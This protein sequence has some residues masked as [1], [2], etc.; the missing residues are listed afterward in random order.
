MMTSVHPVVVALPL[1]HETPDIVATAAEFARRIQA[2]IVV[3]HAIPTRR[4]ESEDGLAARRDGARLRLE[5]YLAPL[6][7]AGVV[8]QDVTVEL[9][10]P[11]EVILAT[12][13]RRAAQMV[14][15]GGGRPA[16]VRRWVVGSVAEAVVRRSS[17][18]VWIARGEPPAGR[19]VLCPVDASPEARVGIDAAIRMARLFAVPLSLMTVV[20]DES[21]G[22]A[23][24]KDQTEAHDWLEALVAKHD[25][26]GLDVS[27]AVAV[28][29][30][31]ERIV[32]AA[33][34]A[35]LAVI[36]S[37]GYDPLIRDWLGPVTMRTLRN[38][39]CSTLTIRHLAEGHDMRMQAI[40]RVAD[41]YQQAKA[42]LVDDHGP[43]A[44]VLLE[45]IVEQAPT[46]AAIQDAYAI[47]LERVGRDVEATSRHAL[48]QLIRD[49]LT[50]MP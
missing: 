15:T 19:P 39:R 43:E 6:R 36:A 8:I 30:P 28:G 41:L 29:D 37:R 35:S 12:A 13:L 32:E 26:Q 48:A 38:S 44:L 10:D 27:L 5:P 9:G 7:A 17:V 3:A 22:E 23:L 45:G 1:D 20:S 31:A 24:A 14:I 11:A 25:V 21:S 2:P 49:R 40:T 18:P 16:T 46:N 50:P 47:A 34:H 33:S 42:L 4:L